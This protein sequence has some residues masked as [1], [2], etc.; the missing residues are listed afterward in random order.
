[1]AIRLSG[2]ASGLDTDTIVKG[3]VDAQK[4]KN[5]KVSDKSTLLEWKQE[6]WKELNTKLFKLYQDDLTKLRLQ[7]S[8][9]TRKV[10]SSDDKLVEVKA[11]NNASIGTNTVEVIGLASTQSVTSI[12]LGAGVNSSSKLKDLIEAKKLTLPSD[13]DGI[14]NIGY[15]GKETNL[16]ITDSTTLGDLVGAFKRAGLNASFDTKQQRLYISAKNSGTDEKF[17][18]ISAEISKNATTALSEI[19]NLLSASSLGG[20]SKDSI[21]STLDNIREQMKGLP[22]AT[23]TLTSLYNK[24]RDNTAGTGTTDA[25]KSIITSLTTLKNNVISSI[26]NKTRQEAL[27]SVRENIKLGITDAEIRASLTETVTNELKVI[28]E[29]ESKTEDEKALLIQSEVDN[30]FNQPEEKD[31]IINTLI[32]KEITS[33]EPSITEGMTKAEYYKKQVDVEYGNKIDGAK[34]AALDSLGNEILNYTTTAIDQ[35]P[36]TSPSLLTAFGLDDIKTDESGNIN[37]SGDGINQMKIV[38][39]TNAEFSFNGVKYE[40]ASNVL[41]V[42]GYTITAKGTTNGQAITLNT[43]NDTQANYDMVKKFVTN[44]NAI[45]KEMNELYYSASSKGYAPLSDEE[46]EAMSDKQIEKWEDKI[47]G[48][49]LKRD[50]A[51]GSLLST[52]NS[53]I[54]ST[55][56]VDGKKYSLSSFGIGTSS[57]YTEKGLLHIDGDADDALVSNL[58]NKLMKALEEEPE[59]VAKVISGVSKKL[60]DTMG[61]KM[62]AIPNIRSA[63]TFYNDKSMVTQQTEYQKRIKIL[64][65]KLTELENK[66]YKQFAAMESAMSKLQSQTNALAGMFGTSS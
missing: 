25:E 60:Y 47:K 38:G 43:I 12:E 64:E 10:T 11:D 3:I 33:A 37:S 29:W 39:G 44:Y 5:K 54:T 28:E 35:R 21:L 45:L 34:K 16:I 2:M 17:T 36:N 61:D 27:N 14:I 48:S 7:G 26:E 62:K 59:V 40:S 51:L 32:N 4:L 30:R 8:F 46:K 56:E 42:N 23:N 41:T 49:I 6:K 63:F 57:D 55:I 1:M 66:Y 31:K 52:M 18:V 65:N 22:D 13:K 19:E 58:T 20:G 24:V 50:D 9:G 15:K 53:T